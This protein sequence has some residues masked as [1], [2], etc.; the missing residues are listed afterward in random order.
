MTASL[1]RAALGESEADEDL[2]GLLA[3]VTVVELRDIAVAEQLAEA[4]EAA[5]LL[6]NRDREQRLALAAEVGALRHVPQ[7]VEVDV[8]A[9][10][11]RDDALVRASPRGRCTS[12]VPRRPARRRARR[13]SGCPRTRPGWRRRSRPCRA[14]RSHRHARGTGQNVSSPT[15]LT[16]TPS[17]KIPTLSRVTRRPAFSDSY[18]PAASSGSTPMMRMSG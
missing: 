5:R 12:S 1:S 14:A 2:R 17:A 10:V 6:R 9:A 4:Q 8:G 18:M 3:L 13:W 7:A 15:R 16:A 11:D